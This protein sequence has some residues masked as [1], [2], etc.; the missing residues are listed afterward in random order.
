M[1]AAKAADLAIVFATQWTTEADDVPDLRL[2]NQQDA[3]IAAIAAAQP[4]TVAVMETGGPVLMPWIDKVPAG[5]AGLVSGGSAAAR[6]WPR[7]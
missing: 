3:L 1:E 5:G 2:P 7:S 4:K 6:R